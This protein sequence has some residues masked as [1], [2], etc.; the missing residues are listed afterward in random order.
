MKTISEYIAE[1]PEL[2]AIETRFRNCLNT[3]S[4]YK[5][6]SQRGNRSVVEYPVADLDRARGYYELRGLVPT[7]AAPATAGTFALAI[8]R[9]PRT[10]YLRYGCQVYRL[11]EGR[12]ELELI[13]SF[14]T[15]NLAA[16][17]CSEKN[18]AALR[19]R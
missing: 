7:S 14:T 11:R 16:D 4:A 5:R 15:A 12:T 3:L 13:A 17:Y 9:A 18:S 6:S 19:H 2:R 1:H 10:A 8:V